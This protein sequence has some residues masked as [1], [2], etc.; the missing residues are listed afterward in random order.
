[1]R[2]VL[3]AVLALGCGGGHRREPQPIRNQAT[4]APVRS[5]LWARLDASGLSPGDTVL[6]A[7]LQVGRIAAIDGDGI[8]EIQV[9]H[10]VEI[11]ANATVRKRP[12]QMLGTFYLELDPGDE[13]AGRRLSPGD[14]I[15]VEPPLGDDQLLRRIEESLPHVEPSTP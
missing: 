5:E 10:G 2:I 1:M 14:E 6:V 12:S 7:G 3:I 8:V 9:P 15:S 4:L 13:S 11:W